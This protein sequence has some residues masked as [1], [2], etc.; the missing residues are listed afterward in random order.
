[1]V[2]LI[3]GKEVVPELV[4]HHFT[5]DKVVARMRKILPD[6]QPRSQMLEGLAS[7]RKLLRGPTSDSLHPAVRAAEAVLKL[8]QQMPIQK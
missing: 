1:M 3:A 2:N 4:Q 6:G 7:V 5:A 8:L